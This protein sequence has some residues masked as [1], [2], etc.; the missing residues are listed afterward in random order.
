MTP[1]SGR[2]GLAALVALCV[3]ALA[4]VAA[5]EI[6]AAWAGHDPWVIPRQRWLDELRTRSWDD[7]WVRV[8]FGAAGVIGLTLFLTQLWPRR[9]A[10]LAVQAEANGQGPVELRVAGQQPPDEAVRVEAD[11]E[12]RALE[13]RLAK[14]AHTVDGVRKARTKVRRRDVVVEVDTRRKYSALEGYVRERVA[15]DLAHVHLQRPLA[16]RVRVRRV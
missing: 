9:P 10:A 12:R 3:L 4:V 11:I 13:S 2:R 1:R 8:V 5:V 7:P 15:D 6:V 14:A 16:L